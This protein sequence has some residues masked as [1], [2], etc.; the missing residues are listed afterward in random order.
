[1]KKVLVVLLA[2]GLVVAFSMP[3]SALENIFGGYW[4]TRAIMEKNFT[5]DD[6]EAMDLQQV[7]TRTRL[8]YTAKF[9]D[10][11]K[12]V[13]KF[14]FDAV[15]GTGPLGDIGSDGQVFEIKNS[16]VDFT[17]PSVNIKA[18]IQGFV[19]G[20]GFLFDDDASG[21]KVTYFKDNLLVPFVWV[22][23]F[24]G[25]AGKDMNDRDVDVYVLAPII[26]MDKITVS[27]YAVWMTSQDINGWGVNLGN[28]LLTIAESCDVYYLGLDVDADL[29]AA[30]VWFTGIYE[31]GDADVNAAVYQAIYGV[32]PPADSVD[33]SAY[34]IAL[35]G[36]ADVTDMASVHGEFFYATGQEDGLGTVIFNGDDLDAFTVTAGQS[37][38]WAEIMGLGI[39]DEQ[40]S[41]GS[42]ADGISDIMAVNLGATAKPM[43]KLS[44]TLDLWY[45][46]LAEDDANGEDD[47]GT[48]VDLIVTYNLMENLNLDFVAAYLFAGDAT[49]GKAKDD[50]NP[51]EIGT[52]LSLSF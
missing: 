30:S 10:Y 12:F 24:E 32:A 35:G 16:Y 37:Y 38:Y 33:V 5:G 18:G 44:V 49:T 9:T 41:N 14:E 39:F 51:Y 13:N 21:L 45:A 29:G 42:C 48:E 22:K 50:A 11:F 2:L 31:F 36:S 52:R 26:K 19:L 47:L 17:V 43:D 8:Y 46:T 15:W 1:M 3:A 4:R 20:R 23:A 7:D 34:L 25:G 40:A 28:P 27:P 6:S